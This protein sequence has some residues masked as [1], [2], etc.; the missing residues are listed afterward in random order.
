MVLAGAPFD[1]VAVIVALSVLGGQPFI[2]MLIFEVALAVAICP[3]GLIDDFFEDVRGPW[4]RRDILKRPTWARC[5]KSS[6]DKK[7][8]L[9]LRNASEEAH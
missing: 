1:V 8:S 6:P 3:R 9:A 5:G 4:R 7:S 2:A